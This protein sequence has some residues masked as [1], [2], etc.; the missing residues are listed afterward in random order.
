MLT[1]REKL[2]AQAQKFVEKGQYD[3]AIREYLKIVAEDEKD[4]R[5]WLKIGDLFA[6][7]GQKSEAAQTYQ[8]VA[9]F[10]ADQG[11]YLKAVAVYKQILKIDPRLI[12]INVALAELY[13]QLGLIQ[14]TISQYELVASFLQHE[15]RTREA[16]DAHRSI[17]ELDPQNV[18]QRIK[19][20][21]LYSKE[22]LVQEAAREFG[23]TADQ[24]R[25]MGR[26]D[27]F[28]KVGERLLFHEPD[29]R[30]IAK[31]LAALYIQRDDPRRALTK[32]QGSF[33]AD[34]RDQ[35]TLDLLAQ[36]FLALN[37]HQKSVSVLKELA[38]VSLE[39]ADQTQAAEAYERILA[40]D[41]NDVEARAAMQPEL[42]DGPAEVTSGTAT[43]GLHRA[44]GEHE[45]P[46]DEEVARIVTE[47]D[48][49]AKY[50][51]YQKAI[52]HLQRALE[53]QPGLR[54]I[55]ERLY[56]L[57]EAVGLGEEAVAELWALVDQAVTQEEAARF[58]GEILRIT[59]ENKAAILRWRRIR[60]ISGVAGYGSWESA[61]AA[62]LSGG[63]DQGTEE[64][65]KDDLAEVDFFLQQNMRNEAQL[66]LENLLLR[67]PHNE[68]L[69]AKL[70][71][72]NAPAEVR[73]AVS[74]RDAT[75]PSMS[76]PPSRPQ[77]KPGQKSQKLDP[78][79]GAIYE[80]TRQGL[81]E[82]GSSS[83]DSES[84]FDLA[85]AYRDMGLYSD[86]IGELRKALQDPR[87][88][89]PCRSLMGL[90]YFD[91]NMPQEA[92]AELRRALGVKGAV[93]RD[94]CEVHYHLGRIHEQANEVKE[95]IAAY[96][97]ALLPG[98]N[99]KDARER[100]SH[101]RQKGTGTAKQ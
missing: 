64:T 44:V 85:T 86:A 26:V 70:R 63:P 91:L 74:R 30:A 61:Q 2:T 35:Q 33:K 62:A 51:L 46:R 57:Y 9:Q 97:Q 50:G 93:P 94:L 25:S 23:E 11:F 65:L 71:E 76:R 73:R 56:G 32:L 87:R 95:A 59:P 21:E 18:A 40:I 98:G 20:A 84:S 19:L 58:L 12:E 92:A 42:F 79:S 38:R 6:K 101:L 45:P 60:A 54:E 77:Q 3:K 4:V 100:L 82:K 10:Y 36:A 89:F 29:N 1:N 34:P 55:R 16:V 15:G 22:N 52:E 72:V 48:V 68:L 24:L 5:T 99:F 7:L 83:S 14:D 78:G 53:R 88:E 27:D 17:L 37:Q 96:E 49:Y 43:P 8:K 31:E 81:R 41:P 67:D 28:L 13:R 90:C 75:E 69:A 66:L 80:M 39:G 47:A